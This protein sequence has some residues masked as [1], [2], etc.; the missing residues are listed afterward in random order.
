MEVTQSLISPL[1]LRSKGYKIT[2]KE[3]PIIDGFYQ[4][5]LPDFS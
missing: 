1:T 4:E 2:S 5:L 3:I